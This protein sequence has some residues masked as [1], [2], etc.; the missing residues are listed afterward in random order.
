MDQNDKFPPNQPDK[1]GQ[2]QGVPQDQSYHQASYHNQ[3]Q[4]Q[5]ASAPESGQ[6]PADPIPANAPQTP[7]YENEAEY[8]V[9]DGYEEESYNEPEKQQPL[10]VRALKKFAKGFLK[11]I[12]YIVLTVV[13][14]GTLVYGCFVIANDAFAFSKPEGSVVLTIE[15]GSGTDTIS[16]V[17]KDNGVIKYKFAFKLY[18]RVKGADGTYQWGEYR[19]D[20]GWSY[21]QIIEALQQPA[22]NYQ[23]V[24]ITIPEGYT[25]EEINALLIEVGIGTA[26][27]YEALYVS[28]F[29]DRYPFL[30]DA[31][32]GVKNHFEGYLH[33]DTYNIYTATTP[34]EVYDMLLSTF[35]ERFTPEMKARAE[36]LGMSEYEVITLASLIEREA[37]TN[38]DFYLVSSV[39]HN[40]L[41]SGEYPMLQSCATVQYILGERKPVLSIADT[42]IDS[43]Y[44]TYINEGLPIGPICSPGSR[45]IDAALYPDD[46]DY[47]FFVAKADGSH[48][49]SKT[50]SEHEAAIDEAN[51]TFEGAE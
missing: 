42:E 14:A 43:P 19:L 50:Y 11:A 33:P 44:N 32:D 15:Q 8:G 31:P 51:A 28:D 29:I 27:D 37:Q 17:L 48:I 10:V 36:E 34:A 40:R 24:D 21:S 16:E 20:T 35:D 38:E 2:D 26:E 22:Q 45:A 7:P 4:D 49:F 13:I 9:D 41:A 30:A 6:I 3:P 18:S 46:T 23:T 25:V 39:F 47:Y 1:N 12:A 5:P